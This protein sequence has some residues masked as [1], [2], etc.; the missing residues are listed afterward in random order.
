MIKFFKAQGLIWAILI[1]LI[2]HSQSFADIRL[3][4]LI[5]NGMVLQRDTPLKIWGWAQ[6]KETIQ[7]I[8]LGETYQAK[9]DENGNWSLIL[10]PLPYGGPH[11]ILF[12]GQ[13]EIVLNDILIGDVWL[14]SGQSNMEINM[15]RVSPLYEED[16]KSADFPLIRYFEV[17]KRYDFNKKNRDLSNGKWQSISQENILSIPAISFFFARSLHLHHDIPV[18]IVNAALGGSP[19]EAWISEESI[20]KFPTYHHELQRFKN[21]DLIKEI[22]SQDAQKS[23]HW[24][25]QLFQKD[26]GYQ[27]PKAW[28]TSE[29]ELDDWE[30]IENPTLWK[31]TAL[32][33]LVGVVWFRKN[34]KL[35][36]S[37]NGKPAAINLGTLIDADS[38]FINGKFI[39]S[40]GYQYPPRRYIIP[41]G[42]LKSGQNSIVVRL[43]NNSGEAG[44]IPDKPYE[45]VF[46]EQKISLEGLWHYKVG[47]QMPPLPAQ[48]FIRWKPVGLYNAMI[49]PLQNY[50]F[51]GVLWYQGESNADR[52]E[53][54]ADLFQTLIQ[55]WR[56]TFKHE[57]LPFLYVQLPNYLSSSQEPQN[58]NWAKLREAQAA[59]LSL[60]NTVMVVAIDL[61]EWNDIHPLNKKDVA[62]RLF[63]QA[64]KLVY[65]ETDLVSSGPFFQ[66]ISNR[67]Q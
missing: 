46:E 62:E 60:P 56:E 45:I 2:S 55:D 26:Q 64:R 63:L 39:G 50:A 28:Y 67:K 34:V 47:A 37:F 12:K 30:E 4:K 54:Y 27:D 43:I 17:P 33:G 19:A 1:F 49:A 15:Q 6:P 22:E 48:T 53:D 3:P 35:P 10:E 25:S 57:E 52:P 31:G 51:K 16:I 23:S 9:A 40:T 24:Y 44:F 8:F 38:V 20:K 18:G 32:E 42:V 7:V 11:Q 29:L 66:I 41:E 65:K 5:S 59:A 13:N 58:S 61:G 36:E 14:V 21:D